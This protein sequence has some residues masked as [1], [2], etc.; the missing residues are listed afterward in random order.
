MALKCEGTKVFLLCLPNCFSM[1]LDSDKTILLLCCKHVILITMS[2]RGEIPLACVSEV[3]LEHIQP[4]NL[5]E[6]LFEVCPF[7]PILVQSQ[8]GVSQ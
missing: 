5:L 3:C 4:D 6:I 8:A 7:L 1:Y 2:S